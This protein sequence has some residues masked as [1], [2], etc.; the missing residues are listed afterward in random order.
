MTMQQRRFDVDYHL[1]NMCANCAAKPAEVTWHIA[2]A[3]RTHTTSKMTMTGRF[4]NTHHYRNL[5][6]NVGVC[7]DCE[8]ALKQEEVLT[9]IVAGIGCT[10]ML[11]G[12][13]GLVAAMG[14]NAFAGVPHSV[15]IVA[16]A[17]G[18]I[19][20]VAADKLI[21]KDKLAERSFDGK[22]FTFRNKRYQAAFAKLNPKL[23][24]R[25]EG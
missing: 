15:F 19:F 16:I 14:S 6:F 10:P 13:L 12:G 11:L 4:K 20:F 8:K 17:A 24:Y 7:K 23:V 22:K 9:R 5:A 25:S 21:L 3:E 18:I 1:P 2:Q